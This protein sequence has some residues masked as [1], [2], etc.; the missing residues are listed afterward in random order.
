MEFCKRV[1]N[2]KMAD[3]KGP[4]EACQNPKFCPDKLSI[5]TGRIVLEF[6][7]MTDMDIVLQESFKGSL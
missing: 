7:D 3:S 5:T 6:R 1:S 4:P 2:F